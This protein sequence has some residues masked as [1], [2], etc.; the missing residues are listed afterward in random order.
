MDQVCQE[1]VPLEDLQDPLEE[2]DC[3]EVE[4]CQEGG[5]HPEEE[6]HM[7]DREEQ[8]NPTPTDLLARNHRSSQETTPKL[9]N[10]LLS[11]TYSSVLTLTMQ[12]CKTHINVA[13]YSSPIS[14]AHTPTSGSSLNINGSSTRLLPMESP[15]PMSGC[16]Q[17]WNVT[18]WRS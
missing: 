9:R 15:S 18:I 3:P 11:G 14:K 16:G 1:D 8:D 7:E 4:D 2:A 17:P 13:Y 5:D 6:D 10:S 12:P